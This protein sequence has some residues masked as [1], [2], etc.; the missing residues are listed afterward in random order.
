MASKHTDGIVR[1]AIIGTGGISGAHGTGYIRHK[2][3]IRVVA[4]CDIVP[5]HMQN[6]AKQL[7]D[8][9]LGVEPRQFSD[10]K[11]LLKEMGDEIDA[12]D[13]CLPHD[14]HGP[15][16]LDAAAAGKHILCEKPMC[17]SLAQADQIAAAVKQ[18]GVIYMSGHNQLFMPAVR[19]A[20]KMIDA[21][22]IGRIRW[23]R[24][25]D[26]FLHPNTERVQW[27][28]RADGKR[29]GGGELID[30]GYH[31]T[32]RLLHLAGSSASAVRGTM[33]RFGLDIDG[34]DSASVQVRFA[35]GA[36]GEV[37]TSWCWNLPHGTHQIHVIGDKAQLFGSD[38]T[39]YYLPHGYTE[40]ARRVLP[41]V[42]TFAEEISHFADCI[43]EN[44][45][46][47]HSVEEGR[48]VLEVILSAAK[49]ADGWQ[50]AAQRKPS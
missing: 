19:Q 40:P 45:R 31:P 34:E 48:A 49:N 44:K 47:I 18:S 16:I 43:K 4:L 37:F 35:S 38:N 41:S 6:R 28:W 22:E 32:Y 42:D 33:G 46:P 21:G 26:C 7:A 17:T 36:I 13:I 5:S 39:L 27:G 12:V 2:D 3:K 10:W 14:L 29:Q 23:I 11:V 30:T 24:S 25:Q 50:D 8:A 9:G 20:K 1:I 15:C